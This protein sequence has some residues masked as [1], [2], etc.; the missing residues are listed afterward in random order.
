MKHAGMV[1]G[2]FIGRMLKGLTTNPWQLEE[3][4]DFKYFQGI[5]VRKHI[6][7]SPYDNEIPLYIHIKQSAH[8]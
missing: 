3:E 7:N 6:Q 1:N 5:K 2:G 8:Y 4:E